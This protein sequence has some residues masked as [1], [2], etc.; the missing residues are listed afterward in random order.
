[1][2]VV[3]IKSSSVTGIHR[4]KVS[5]HEDVTL[6]VHEDNSIPHIDPQCMKVMF[7]MHVDAQLREEIVWPKTGQRLSW[8]ESWERP[9]KFGWVVQMPSIRQSSV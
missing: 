7:P 5:S 6:L 9:C 1:M 4:T 3:T 8:Q 2:A